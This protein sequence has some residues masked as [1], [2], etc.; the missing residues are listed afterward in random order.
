MMNPMDLA[1]GPKA[2]SFNWGKAIDG[3]SKERGIMASFSRCHI[4]PAFAA[5][6]GVMILSAAV[7]W[8][9]NAISSATTSMKS[10]NKIA[11]GEHS[12]REERSFSQGNRPGRNNRR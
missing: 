10:D 3:P 9:S 7:M 8:I 2:G 12:R 11:S 4:G 5:V 1:T 6:L